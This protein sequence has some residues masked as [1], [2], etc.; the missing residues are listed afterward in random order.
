MIVEVLDGLAANG[1][2]NGAMEDA[3]RRRVEALCQRFPIYSA[4]YR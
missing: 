2:D 3:V 1:D 4:M